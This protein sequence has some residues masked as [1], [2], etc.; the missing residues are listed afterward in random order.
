MY[1]I[2]N[3][4]EL[5][6][7]NPKNSIKLEYDCFVWGKSLT[8]PSNQTVEYKYLVLSG[9]SVKWEGRPN[10]KLFV[11]PQ[12][13]DNVFVNDIWDFETVQER[14]FPQG[15]FSSESKELQLMTYNVRYDSPE[16]GKNK[17]DNRK[18]FVVE[19]IKRQ[20]P[21]V[22]GVQEPLY[23]Q[24]VYLQ[25]ELQDYSFVG[26]GRDGSTRGEFTPIFY[27]KDKFSVIEQK[28]FWLSETPEVVGSKSWNAV[29][30]R[31]KKA[32]KERK[33][34]L[35]SFLFSLKM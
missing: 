17:W 35:T 11:S 31:L 33:K 25:Q 1:L 26:E 5:G 34:F 3:L 29:C 20:S 30:V 14:H 28:T 6:A 24:V 4:P 18:Q 7:W 2:G 23:H 22:V 13:K 19:L 8:L 12:N 32:K 16:D 21:D 27:K 10:R 15:V 9:K